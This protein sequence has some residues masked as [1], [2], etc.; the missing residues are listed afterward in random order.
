MG[1]QLFFIVTGLVSMT[2]LFNHTGAARLMIR[3]RLVE[4]PAAPMSLQKKTILLHIK[5]YMKE[6]VQKALAELEHE[7]GEFTK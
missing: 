2:L 5:R 4:D 7:L 6:T 1:G 3:L